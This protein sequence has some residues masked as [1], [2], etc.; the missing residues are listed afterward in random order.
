MNSRFSEKLPP[1]L[2]PVILALI[3][4]DDVRSVSCPF[5]DVTLWRALVEKQIQHAQLTGL[6]LQK[7]YALCG[8]DSGLDNVPYQEWG[9]EIH[10]PYEGA[11]GGD[12]FI[13]PKWHR[14]FAEK[15]REGGKLRWTVAKRCHHVLLRGDYGEIAC[16]T[17]QQF[18][19]WTLYTSNAPYEPCNPFVDPEQDR[20]LAANKAR[21]LASGE[22]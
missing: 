8:P 1:E 14:F 12:L 18:G 7:A 6:P 20:I 9:G 3:E 22:T 11:C 21:K 5:D 4:R 10:V 17:R 15:V 13:L 16:A 19:D 2:Y